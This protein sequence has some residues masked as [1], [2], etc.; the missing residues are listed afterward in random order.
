MTS[1]KR[2]LLCFVLKRWTLCWWIP[3][4]MGHCAGLGRSKH[5]CVSLVISCRI[6]SP[7]TVIFYL[8]LKL[9][10]TRQIEQF[11][12]PTNSKWSIIQWT[13]EDSAK[14]VHVIGEKRGKTCA[15][16]LWLILVSISDWSRLGPS[17]LKPITKRGKVKTKQRGLL[18]TL[19][20]KWLLFFDKWISTGL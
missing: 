7:L 19:Q 11:F 3:M 14:Q 2:V 4:Y 13:N 10:K 20:Q 15:N 18:S 12:S 17:F 1:V 16:E 8:N 5:Q 9:A 6:D